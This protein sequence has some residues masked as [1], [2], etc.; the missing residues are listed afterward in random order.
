ME[1][2]LPKVDRASVEFHT[3]PARTQSLTKASAIDV[4]SSLMLQGWVPGRTCEVP[5]HQ[6]LHS[7]LSHTEGSCEIVWQ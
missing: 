7:T 2:N 5:V 6:P 3:V 1:P 4:Y